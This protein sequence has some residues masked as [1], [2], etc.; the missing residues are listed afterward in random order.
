MQNVKILTKNDE[1]FTVPDAAKELKLHFTTIPR[2]IEKDKVFSFPIH[3]VEQLHINQVRALKLKMNE[4][5]LLPRT[6]F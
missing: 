1:L 5:Q 3:D 6:S 2:V 4:G